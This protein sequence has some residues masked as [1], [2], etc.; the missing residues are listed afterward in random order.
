[1]TRGDA[2]SS[3]LCCLHEGNAKDKRQSLHEDLQI[4]EFIESPET[5]AK[6]YGWRG[7]E[8]S[9]SRWVKRRAGEVERCS[10]LWF[11]PSRTP[12]PLAPAAH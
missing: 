10:T 12:E 11:E 7:R 1:M 4:T 6:I 3:H 5:G 9:M 2:E 8:R